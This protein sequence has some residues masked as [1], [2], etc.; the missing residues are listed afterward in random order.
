M[1]CHLMFDSGMELW[2]PRD[3]GGGGR[4]CRKGGKAGYCRSVAQGIRGLCFPR[5]RMFSISCEVLFASSILTV[6][7]GMKERGSAE[8]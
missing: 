2:V 6:S 4:N 8:G 1:S 3:C 7:V 5:H